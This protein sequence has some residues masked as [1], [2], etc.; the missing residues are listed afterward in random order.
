MFGKFGNKVRIKSTPETEEKGLAG[1]TGEILGETTPSMMDFKIVGSPKEDYA[2]NVNIEELNKSFWFD[3][4][5][6]EH[7]D[8]GQGTEITLL[9]I[10][11]KWTKLE[12]GKWS[13]EAVIPFNSNLDIHVEN[14]INNLNYQKKWWEFWKK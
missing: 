2:V 6:I 9:G 10:E 7:L 8:D 4:D 3:A 5:L 13:E 1:K 11:K 14:H 12:D